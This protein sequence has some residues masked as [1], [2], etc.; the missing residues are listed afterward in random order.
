MLRNTCIFTF[1]QHYLQQP[2]HGND[3]GARR[4]M[5][6]SKICDVMCV[7]VCVCEI[8]SGH[9]EKEIPPLST[10]WTLRALCL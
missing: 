8:L 6:G 7:C 9:S 5:N 3:L 2:S 10:T 1:L 4:D